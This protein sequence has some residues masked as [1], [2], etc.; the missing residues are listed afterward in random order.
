MVEIKVSH[1]SH[2][3]C[4]GP[5]WSD[6][7]CQKPSR[8]LMPAGFLV[9]LLNRLRKHCRGEE[10]KNSHDQRRRNSV[11]T[12]GKYLQP[13]IRVSV[14]RTLNQIFKI[15]NR[16]V[17]FASIME[18]NNEGFIISLSSARDV[19]HD[20]CFTFPRCIG[21]DGTPLSELLEAVSS[22]SLLDIVLPPVPLWAFPLRPAR[23][24]KDPTCAGCRF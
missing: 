1:I 14:D 11:S 20:T 9:I 21:E 18:T 3:S 12:S 13:T 2:V 22:L 10:E 5:P 17:C 19:E 4:A 8:H 6:K 23:V 24:R 15:P 7:I 16:R